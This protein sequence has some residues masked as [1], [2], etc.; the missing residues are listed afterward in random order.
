M[1]KGIGKE[2]G[3]QPVPFACSYGVNEII[4]YIT[5]PNLGFTGKIYKTESLTGAVYDAESL[6]A[7]DGTVVYVTSPTVII[8]PVYEDVEVGG[9]TSRV[10]TGGTEKA[11]A[12]FYA[13]AQS[14]DATYYMAQISQETGLTYSECTKAFLDN[15]IGGTS[16]N[17]FCEL[18]VF[19][20]NPAH[21][22]GNGDGN[23]SGD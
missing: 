22:N 3:T 13:L 6:R 17:S 1:I 7:V 2:E 9:G 19:T 21:G 5:D 8:D 14:P 15:L 23:G 20:T 11:F 18:E 12:D 4:P 16:F 10:R